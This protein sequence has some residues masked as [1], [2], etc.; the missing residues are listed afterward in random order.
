GHLV[1][2]LAPLVHELV[3]VEVQR[4]EVGSVQIPVRLLAEQREVDQLDKNVLQL[5]ADC[6]A[7]GVTE[8][9]M[10]VLAGGMCGHGSSSLQVGWLDATP[11]LHELP[12]RSRSGDREEAEPVP[13]I[14]R[15]APKAPRF[16][17]QLA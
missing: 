12:K 13:A 16:R 6:L 11:V 14:A 8:R 1:R 9:R 10:V 17:M 2:R 15:R 7:V 5:G 3:E 4:A